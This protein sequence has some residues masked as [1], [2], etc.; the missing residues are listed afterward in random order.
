MIYLKRF[1]FIFIMSILYTL[2]FF[3][4]L[5]YLLFMPIGMIISFIIAEDFTKFFNLL[6]HLEKYM[7]FITNKLESIFLK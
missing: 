6:L 2:T 4:I 3:V 1:L 7:T 5:L